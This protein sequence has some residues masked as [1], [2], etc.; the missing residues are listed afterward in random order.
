LGRPLAGKLGIKVGTTV[1]L[2]GAPPAFRETLGDLPEGVQVQED[3]ERPTDLILWFLRSRD[4]LH[5][6]IEAMS[7]RLGQGRLWI[8]WPKKASGAV[9]DLRQQDVREAGLAA[10]LVDYK[11][12]SI[13]ATWSG[14]L[15]T[16]RRG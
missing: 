4:E 16:R 15:F 8:A 7:V 12:V 3:I 2:V 13:D 10:G 11:I 14:L 9:T 1:A 6:G 5:R